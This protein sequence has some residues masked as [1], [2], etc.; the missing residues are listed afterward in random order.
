MLKNNIL[1]RFNPQGIIT[2]PYLIKELN[3]KNIVFLDDIVDKEHKVTLISSTIYLDFENKIYKI[4]P[5]EVKSNMI[6]VIEYKT[7][8]DFINSF[9]NNINIWSTKK[10]FQCTLYHNQRGAGCGKTYESIQLMDKDEKFKHKELFIYLTKAHSAKEV[11]YNELKEQYNRGEL[12][13][14]KIDKN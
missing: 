2:L 11:I 8:I 10:I 12:L 13:N 4:N 6:D 1:I 5:N 9:K 14:L 7:K 3:I